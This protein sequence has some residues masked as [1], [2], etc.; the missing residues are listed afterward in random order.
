MKNTS[1]PK[2]LAKLWREVKRPFKKLPRVL[3]AH[4]QGLALTEYDQAKRFHE[5]RRFLE[6]ERLYTSCTPQEKQEVF[7]KYV[8]FVEIETFS[9][10]NRKCWFCPNSYID[11]HSSNT[12]MLPE[13]YSKIVD[14]LA[15]I[16][17]SGSI[18]YSRYNE[19]FSDPVIL[20]RI[21]E[22][23]NKLPNVSLKTYSNGDYITSEL[24]ERLAEAGMNE[25]R[26]MRYPVSP[27]KCYSSDE[28]TDILTGFA[29]KVNLP[30]QRIESRSIRLLHPKLELEVRIFPQSAIR[31]R[32]GTVK[33]S[34]KKKFRTT[35]CYAPFTNLYIDHNGSVMPCCN[36]RSDV[37]QH[38]E[39]IMGNVTD[40][41]LF[42]IYTS[43]RYSL[44]RYQM[45]DI[46]VKVYP[47]NVCDNEYFSFSSNVPVHQNRTN[48]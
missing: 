34:T 7:A 40:K 14:E 6:D 46:G 47:C 8:H 48:S 18:R 45:R 29:S 43:L 17:Y 32:A 22:A 16:G 39:M 25:I 10:C 37:P 13:V 30:Y 26:I 24:L 41:A 33:S 28:I 11:R 44:L 27:E 3:R 42:E 9:F 12:L 15:E 35:P 19:P 31:N 20:D 23:R 1:E 4:F 38:A 5:W 21:R 2:G 36:M